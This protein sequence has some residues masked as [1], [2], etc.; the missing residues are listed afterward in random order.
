MIFLSIICDCQYLT[1]RILSHA[2]AMKG[3]IIL[4]VVA[5]HDSDSIYW[6]DVFV[7]SMSIAFLLANFFKILIDLTTQVSPQAIDEKILMMHLNL[8]NYLCPIVQLR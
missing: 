7:T 8:N 3:Q 5:I 1:C 6:C 4:E 2:K